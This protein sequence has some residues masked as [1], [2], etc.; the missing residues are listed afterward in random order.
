MKLATVWLLLALS[1]TAFAE[2][3]WEL[4]MEVHPKTGPQATVY[5]DPNS[6]QR[7][8]DFR[9]VWLLYDF[10]PA[11]DGAASKM[12]LHEV[13]C[14]QERSREVEFY[15]YAKPMGKEELSHATNYQRQWAFI[16]PQARIGRPLL[17]RLCDLW[18]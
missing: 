13:D 5:L 3:E 12:W 8:G 6:I 18:R 16:T 7:D 14:K 11:S 2:V 15:S 10:I 9:R 1:R 4:L 17:K